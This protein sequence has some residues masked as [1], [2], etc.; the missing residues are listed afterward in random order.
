MKVLIFLA[1]LTCSIA[2]V[3]LA[4]A[5]PPPP[6]PLIWSPPTATDL[7]EFLGGEGGFKAM[8]PGLAKKS[9]SSQTNIAVTVYSVYRKGSISAVTV[10]SFP[11]DIESRANEFYELYKQNLAVLAPKAPGRLPNKK[12][13]LNF[14]REVEVAGRKAREFGYVYDYYYT[15]VAVMIVGN[16]VYAIS[17]DVTNW[18]IL[19][20]YNREVVQAFVK[21]AERFRNS[22]SLVK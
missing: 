15:Q 5:P 4:Q 10:M 18:H 12:F 8:F 16:Q 19:S 11:S 7:S 20:D 1:L 22:F 21:E 14:D 2:Q 3:A 6:P 17:S 9:A 13:V